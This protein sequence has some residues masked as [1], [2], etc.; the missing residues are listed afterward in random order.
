MRAHRMF[1][2]HMVTFNGPISF[3]KR[4]GR[5]KLSVKGALNFIEYSSYIVCSGFS[6][7]SLYRRRK[8]RTD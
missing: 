4:F 3:L 7:F 2:L 8:N 5:E 6:N 1:N